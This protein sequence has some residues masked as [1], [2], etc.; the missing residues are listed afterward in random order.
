MLNILHGFAALLFALLLELFAGNIFAV[1]PFSSCVLN[2]V[3]EKFPLPFVFLSGF[4]TGLV[5]DL[6]YWR[7]YPGSALAAGTTVTLVRLI[8]D[9]SKISNSLLNALLKGALTGIFSVFLMVLFNGYADSRRLP[10]KYHIA[11]SFCGAVIFQLLISVRRSQGN[12]APEH[13]LPRERK[14][15]PRPAGQNGKSPAPSQSRGR[16]KTK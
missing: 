16:R 5:L 6:I 14:K 1:I 9:R 11:T 10:E 7:S 12:A 3:T 15:T 4:L 2:R 8:S 13:P